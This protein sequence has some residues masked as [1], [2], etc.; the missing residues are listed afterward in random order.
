MTR[1][2]A[3]ELAALFATEA[4]HA[5]DERDRAHLRSCQRWWAD[6]SSDAERRANEK[7]AA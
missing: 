4:A 1:E 5:T 3:L 2:L 6:K 7:G